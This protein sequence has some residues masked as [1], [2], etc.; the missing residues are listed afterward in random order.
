MY[1]CDTSAI[2][3]QTLTQPRKDTFLMA[4]TEATATDTNSCAQD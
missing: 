1:E 2:E 3:S 4:S